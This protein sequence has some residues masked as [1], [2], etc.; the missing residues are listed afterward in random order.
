MLMF[1]TVSGGDNMNFFTSYNIA[2]NP[3]GLN[4]HAERNYVRQVNDHLTWIYRTRVGS[5]LL[6]AIKYHGLPVEI[7][8]YGGADCNAVGGGVVAAGALQGVVWY[9]PDTFSIHGVCSPKH[10]AQNRGLLWDEILFHE[11]VHVFRNV[12]RKW[13]KRALIGGMYRYDDTEEFVAVMVTNIYISD[14][15]NRIKTGLRA[16]HRSF[17]P[18][19]PEFSQPFGIFSSGTQVFSLVKQ[20]CID[21]PGFTRRVANDVADAQFNPLADYYASPD[22]AEALSKKALPRDLAGVLI[23]IAEALR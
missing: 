13:S 22:R 8:P 15:S 11:L 12:S 20:F 16:D 4:G 21:N 10:S 6:K 7:R 14:R 5:I 3:V 18:L 2:I 17:G 9:S 23:Q 19:A 1:V